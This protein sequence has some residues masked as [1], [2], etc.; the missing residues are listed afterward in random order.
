MI[1]VTQEHIDRAISS[2]SKHWSASNCPIAFALK[3]H[4]NKEVCVTFCRFEGNEYQ[5]P[6]YRFDGQSGYNKLPMECKEFIKRFDHNLEVKPFEFE[7]TN[8]TV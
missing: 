1:K 7:V 2:R 4:L 8:G 5:D 3:E 6:V